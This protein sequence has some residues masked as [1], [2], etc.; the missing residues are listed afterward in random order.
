MAN[1]ASPFEARPLEEVKKELL[2][3]AQ[4]NRNPFLYTLYE[5]VAPVLHA[6]RSVDREQ[7]ASAFSALAR[8]HEQRAAQACAEY[9]I[10]Y[11]CY[12]A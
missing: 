9:L 5:E 12:L 1:A 6:L 10:A 2:G 4:A 3:R 11:D 8:P 7:W